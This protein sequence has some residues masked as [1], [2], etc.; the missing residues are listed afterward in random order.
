MSN[1]RGNDP[2]R[3]LFIA[4]PHERADV[5]ASVKTESE[6]PLKVFRRTKAFDP[7]RA[8]DELRELSTAWRSHSSAGFS[9]EFELD[10]DA[11]AA[12][13]EQGMVTANEV[14]FVYRLAK[15]IGLL[16]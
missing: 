14:H 12:A 1:G 8:L 7:E 11:L 15:A 6:H 2:G 5:L 16:G 10:P 3:R 9:C 4:S 13:Y